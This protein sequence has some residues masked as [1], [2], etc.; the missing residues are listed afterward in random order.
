MLREALT[1]NAVA[2][3]V[4]SRQASGRFNVEF[5]NSDVFNVEANANYDLLL[6]PFSPAPGRPIPVG[7]YHY[8]DMVMSYSM[9]AYSDEA[10]VS[11][12]YGRELTAARTQAIEVERVSD[13]PAERVQ[14]WRERGASVVS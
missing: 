12:Q 4:E 14:A 2:G 6:V 1:A 5:N 9:I 13:D 8:N 3:D 11:E 7:G 10:F